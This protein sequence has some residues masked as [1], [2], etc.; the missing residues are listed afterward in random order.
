MVTTAADI[1]VDIT[2]AL[3]VRVAHLKLVAVLHQEAAEAVAVF[4][5][6]PAEPALPLTPILVA[7]IHP[8][9]VFQEPGVPVGGQLGYDQP[10]PLIAVQEYVKPFI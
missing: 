2:I 6:D 7:F 1:M 10:E 5:P 4:M 3:N 9:A 8:E